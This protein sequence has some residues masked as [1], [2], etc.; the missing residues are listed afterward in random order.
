MTSGR[1]RIGQH[2]AG[3]CGIWRP[4]T[5][6]R[7]PWLGKGQHRTAISRKRGSYLPLLLLAQDSCLFVPFCLLARTLTRLLSQ[8][9]LL[10][11]GLFSPLLLLQFGLAS[12][13]ERLTRLFGSAL[14]LLVLTVRRRILLL[15][16]ARAPRRF[17]RA[18]K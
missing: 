11:A 8:P 14:L 6:L 4:R 13:L 10:L 15:V 12:L 7:L 3:I 2:R 5:R 1:L 16:L 9:R 18:P 17:L